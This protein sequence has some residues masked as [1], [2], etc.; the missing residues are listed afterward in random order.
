ML[1]NLLFVII[2][3]L[4]YAIFK[5]ENSKGGRVAYIKFSAIVLG[6]QSAL[7]HIAVGADTYS[8]FQQF[9]SVKTTT[10]LEVFLSFPEVYIY[11]EGKDPGYL[12]LQKVFQ[13]FSGDF[14]LFLFFVA[15]IFFYAYAQVL[16]K[17]TRNTLEV[18]TANFGYLAL[19]YSF[20]SITGLR[21]TISVA[22]GILFLLSLIDKKYI[23]SIIFF[24]IAFI[25]H[26]SSIFL[27][28]I[29]LLY[30]FKRHGFLLFLY[31]IA[32]IVFLLSRSY[33]VNLALVLSDYEPIELPLPILLDIFYF[34][35][36]LFIWSRI[37][38]GANNEI[39]SLFNVYAL[40]FAWIP[41]LGNDSPLMRAI[42]YFNIYILVLLPRA[43]TYTSKYRNLL[44][45]SINIFFIYY[46]LSSRINYKFFWE[47]LQLLD[48]YL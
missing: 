27:L 22:L 46:I 7:R 24:I 15:I 16:I 40:T 18:L 47:E 44:F 26:K 42:L 12:L 28:L 23:K 45:L 19:F 25:I 29:P 3:I 17:Y 31:V 48:H 34:V 2:L 30:Y 35:M 32:F 20:Y 8:Y 43:I 5:N 4:G 9:E 36:T 1:H 14:R 11:G 13:I 6:L 10:W 33:F 21:Q 38:K 41:L 37:R 39:M